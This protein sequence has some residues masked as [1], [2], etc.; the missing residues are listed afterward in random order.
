M[1]TWVQCQDS[2]GPRV[3]AVAEKEE[4][5]VPLPQ[6]GR[7]QWRAREGS[8][9]R[10]VREA[11][12]VPGSPREQAPAPNT[13]QLCGG[14]EEAAVSKTEPWEGAARTCHSI[15]ATGKDRGGRGSEELWSGA[16][17]AAEAGGT[18][19]WPFQRKGPCV[20]G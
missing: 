5:S 15:T 13:C 17:R 12:G 18:D 8:G 10:A 20:C 3:Q 16:R 2:K 4:D 7:L 1:A 11:L 9:A 14:A 19:G 6:R